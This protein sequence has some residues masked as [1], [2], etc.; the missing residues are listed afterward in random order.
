MDSRLAAKVKKKYDEMRARRTAEKLLLETE[1]YDA[2]PQLKEIEEKIQRCGIKYNR[3]VL[4]GDKDPE[5]A[6]SCLDA[7]IERLK[8]KR[9]ELLTEKG[10]PSDYLKI[11]PYCPKCKDEGFINGVQC[12]CFMG[13]I[14]KLSFEMSNID[15]EGLESWE[16]YSEDLYS[17]AVNEEK[18]GMKISPRSNIK[19]IKESCMRFIHNI[20]EPNE[21]NLMFYGHAGTGKTFTAKCVAKELLK[22]GRTA[23]YMSAP[24]LFDTIGRYKAKAYKEGR[25]DDPLYSFIYNTEVLIIDDL[26]TE[27]STPSRY[28]ELLNI[29]NSRDERNRKTACKTI[30]ATNLSPSKLFEYYDERVASRI[31]GNF[32]RLIFAGDDIRI[33][34]AIETVKSAEKRRSEHTGLNES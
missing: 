30:I 24:D 10:Y 21:K 15:P 6:S 3:M 14:S 9:S 25:F 33:T 31:I 11:E 2:V 23:L 5:E 13:E 8:K 28:A 17:D 22:K 29:L 4:S 19:K 27:A 26:G 1:I 32:D 7:E 16:N 18:Y 12:E 20:D 34:K